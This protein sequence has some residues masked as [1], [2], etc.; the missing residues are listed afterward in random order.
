MKITD[1]ERLKIAIEALEFYKR[2]CK[3]S[4]NLGLISTK[5]NEALKQIKK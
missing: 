3:D 5:I 2:Y 4:R 1:S